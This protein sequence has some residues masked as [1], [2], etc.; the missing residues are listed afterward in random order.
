MTS[1]TPGTDGTTQDDSSTRAATNQDWDF[2][3]DGQNDIVEMDD[4][5]YALVIEGGPAIIADDPQDLV[6]LVAY[7]E[8]TVNYGLAEGD[9]ATTFG[10]TFAN[11]NS[12]SLLDVLMSGY[13]TQ[14]D[15]LVPGAAATYV[16]TQDGKAALQATNDEY[17]GWK[18]PMYPPGLEP[19]LGG[20]NI[21]LTETTL[22]GFKGAAKTIYE[23]NY[24]SETDPPLPA[25]PPIDANV[26]ALLDLMFGPGQHTYGQLNV[27]KMMGLATGGADPS[28]WSV[29]PKG[30]ALLETGAIYAGSYYP[31][32]VGL[33]CEGADAAVEAAKGVAAFFTSDGTAYNDS[34]T[35][36]DVKK[37]ARN[38]L[39]MYV[40]TDTG[41]VTKTGFDET[42]MST[43]ALNMICSLFDLP[44][45]SQLTAEQVSVAVSMGLVAC[46]ST[47][48]YQITA[49]GQTFAGT[50]ATPPSD[51]AASP[52]APAGPT[53][54]TRAAYT[55]PDDS[56][57]KTDVEAAYAADQ[58]ARPTAT[59]ENTYTEEELIRMGFAPEMA[60][61][62]VRN[63]GDGSSITLEGLQSLET[64]GYFNLVTV[65]G[66]GNQASEEPDKGK[67]MVIFED[68]KSTGEED[69][70]TCK[71][72]EMMFAD[73]YWASTNGA[74]IKDATQRRMQSFVDTAMDMDS[75]G[76]VK[77]YGI[78][79]DHINQDDYDDYIRKLEKANGVDDMSK[80]GKYDRP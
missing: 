18:V 50:A 16:L 52:A 1:I 26:S 77:A 6:N 76:A 60:D 17:F 80:V 14:S 8:L 45:G 32:C 74:A 2:D 79:D 31:P 54:D 5:R 4:G 66:D 28:A 75:K 29:M 3:D 30:Q 24:T 62:L 19:Y 56:P 39:G 49:R 7:L 15:T 22:A 20:G 40:N 37:L 12:L 33:L 46:D 61:W 36:D 47:G 69:H 55:Y 63:C 11:F 38:S 59:D 21:E 44:P 43:E 68:A 42:T 34:Y 73:P 78:T 67:M 41:E 53:N 65:E 57:Y 27:L 13:I 51:T 35:A 71:F 72:I 10:D 64:A 25:D 70:S 9:P 48:A 23:A 58:A